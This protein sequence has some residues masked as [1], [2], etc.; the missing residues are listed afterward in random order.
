MS[1]LAADLLL[2]LLISSV[3]RGCAR[4]LHYR[5]APYLFSKRWVWRGSLSLLFHGAVFAGV[6][7]M[8]FEMYSAPWWAAAVFGSIPVLLAVRYALQVF[9]SPRKIAERNKRKWKGP[10]L[11]H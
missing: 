6:S 7:L 9:R 3:L 8:L 2:L 11:V 4:Q 1:L 10:E 5:D